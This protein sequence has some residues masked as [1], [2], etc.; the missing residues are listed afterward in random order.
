MENKTQS[1]REALWELMN[2]FEDSLRYGVRGRG[3]Y[4]DLPPAKPGSGPARVS[5]AVP[6]GLAATPA[7]VGT[8]QPSLTGRKPRPEPERPAPAERRTAGQ[9]GTGIGAEPVAGGQVASAQSDATAGLA[10]DSLH[11]IAAEVMACTR[12]GLAETRNLAVPGE[13]DAENTRVLVVG[14]APGAEEDRQIGR[15]HV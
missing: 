10:D 4:P 3:E 2:D 6:P 8:A 13:G 15:A 7:A 11:S 9:S 12:C 1:T 5:G 14:E